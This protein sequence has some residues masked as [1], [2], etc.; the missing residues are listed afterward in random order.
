V[1]V[2]VVGGVTYAETLVAGQFNAVRD[3]H[4]LVATRTE[5]SWYVSVSA[6]APVRGV[7]VPRRTRF[8]R[9]IVD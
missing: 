2:F 5:L 9:D 1:I 7:A 8:K 4:H 3:G 6:D